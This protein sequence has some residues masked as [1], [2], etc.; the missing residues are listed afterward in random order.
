MNK[1]QK[2]TSLKLS[3]KIQ[4]KAIEKEFELPRAEYSWVTDNKTGKAEIAKSH[5][6]FDNFNC[7]EYSYYRAYDTSELGEMLEKYRVPVSI[8]WLLKAEKN[9]A[10]ARGEVFFYLLDNDLL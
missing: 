1:E 4:D 9:E 5:K 2:Y 10:E 6:P 3:K 8:W 7:K